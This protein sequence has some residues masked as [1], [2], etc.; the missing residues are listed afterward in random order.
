[1]TIYTLQE[2]LYIFVDLR[3]TQSDNMNDIVR[4]LL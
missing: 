1:M 4:W 2:V 3:S